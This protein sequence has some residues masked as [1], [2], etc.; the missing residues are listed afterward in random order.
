LTAAIATVPANGSA[1]SDDLQ[2]E[3]YRS[4]TIR[5][6]DGSPKCFHALGSQQFQPAAVQEVWDL[7]RK[8]R[9]GDW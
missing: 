9:A 4:V 7:V 8:C 2:S 3:D 6:A 5:W 1:Y